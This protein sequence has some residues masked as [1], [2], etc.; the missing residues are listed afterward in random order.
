MQLNE[1]QSFR[2]EIAKM[3]ASLKDES[4]D[5]VKKNT[6]MNFLKNMEVK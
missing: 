6:L 5:D 3:K 1:Q 2:D 4:L